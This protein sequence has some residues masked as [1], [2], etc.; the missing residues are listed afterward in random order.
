MNWNNSRKKSPKLM[1]FMSKD[2]PSD[3]KQATHK[4][5]LGVI[6]ICYYSE[7]YVSMNST[8]KRNQKAKHSVWLLRKHKKPRTQKS[9]FTKNNKTPVAGEK[10]LIIKT[11]IVIIWREIK[12]GSKIE[13]EYNLTMD[14]KGC[15]VWTDSETET[16]KEFNWVRLE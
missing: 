6:C 14:W 8:T 10:T 12:W 4:W 9:K 3:F 11:G 7:N 15:S 1:N 16:E 2:Y 5:L 13:I